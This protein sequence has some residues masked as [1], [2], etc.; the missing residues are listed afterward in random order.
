MDKVGFIGYGHMG[1]VILKGLLSTTGIEPGQV[2]ISTRTRNKLDELKSIHP[3]IEIAENNREVAQKSS[4][5]FLCIGTYQV[6]SVLMEIRDVLHNEMHLVTISGGLEIASVER[7]FDGPITKVIPTI[8]SEVQ[9]G[10]TLVS[11]NAKVSQAGKA[12]L[13]QLFSKIGEVKVIPEHQFEMGADFTSCAPGL[14]A[15]ICEQFVQAGVRESDFTYAEASEMFLH[16]LYGTAKLLLQ[17]KEDFKALTRRVAT[18]GGATEGGVSVLEAN[19]PEVFE[20]VFAV[21]LQRHEARKQITR[22]QF[23]ELLT[24]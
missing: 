22:Q 23:G 7:I 18:K 12:Y 9:E 10:V 15:S 20:K 2:I 19:L 6:K 3:D 5:L 4:T 16:T 17:N 13:F 21:T 14:L 24:L 8:I 1:S 11:H